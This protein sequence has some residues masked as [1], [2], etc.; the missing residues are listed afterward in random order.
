MKK[1]L[2]ISLIFIVFC[3]VSCD[4]NVDFALWKK[5]P[6]T[7]TVIVS[8]AG[9]SG[10]YT[11]T[12]TYYGTE[13]VAYQWYDGLVIS[14]DKKIPEATSA[15]FQTPIARS[16]TVLVT[17][18]GKYC[19][20][21][22]AVYG[23]VVSGTMI[24]MSDGSFKPVEEIE[25]LD[26]IKSYDFYSGKIVSNRV[27]CIDETV[28]TANEVLT[29]KTTDGKVVKFVDCQTF[30]DVDA[31]EF[32]DITDSNYSSMVGKNIFVKEGDSLKKT[33]IE[34]INS[35]VEVVSYFELIVEKSF[36]F[37]AGGIMTTVPDSI[38]E[39]L[40]YELD[41][42]YKYDS[43]KME[44]D[45]ALYGLYS[46]ETCPFNV[47]REFFDS[48][49]VAH[50]AVLLGKGMISEE[51]VEDVINWHLGSNIRNAFKITR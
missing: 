29:L 39:L 32:F 23:C 43:I 1:I 44:Q 13:T 10:N 35:S 31:K 46:Y 27:V 38:V 20:Y 49:G 9:T 51:V 15:I 4:G 5:I 45:Q 30:F 18:I 17:G 37:F 8:Q 33:T 47:S 21:K 12:A 24:E 42:D 6:I 22:Y 50:Y 16:Y 36:N 26:E 3:V 19:G 28:N 48:Y 34:S 11:Y 25:L 40:P 2:F 41:S 14:D 7:G